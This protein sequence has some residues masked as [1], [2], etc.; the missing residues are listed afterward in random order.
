MFIF[1]FVLIFNLISKEM[2]PYFINY[3]RFKSESVVV[4]EV[5]EIVNQRLSNNFINNSINSVENNV[6][7]I[8]TSIINSIMANVVCSA[9]KTISNGLVYI[10]PANIMFN[11]ILWFDVGLDIPVKAHPVEN[12]KG[13]I[14][15]EVKEYGI[16]NAMIDIV[17][18]LD[19]SIK[20]IVPYIKDSVDFELSF[21]LVSKIVQG[22]IPDYY[23]G[24]HILGEIK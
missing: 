7:N 8:N 22:D 20:I 14:V 10:V 5:N 15:S 11:D 18:I 12:I 23:V 1:V 16:N 21:P 19:V 17:L 2:K 3:I 9:N 4:K 24:S 6:I 13:K